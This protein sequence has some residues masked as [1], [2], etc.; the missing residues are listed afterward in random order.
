MTV[1]DELITQRRSIRKYKPEIPPVEWIEAMIRAAIQAPSPSNNQPVRFIRIISPLLKDK[2]FQAMADGRK[3]MLQAILDTNSP[4]KLKNWVS[5]YF[6]F[7]AF[8][9]HAPVLFALGTVPPDPVLTGK[10][11]GAGILRQDHPEQKD[12]DIAVGLSLMAYILKG[13][14]LGIGSCILT[15][16][17]FFIEDPNKALALEGIDIKC[18]ITS[19]YPDEEPPPMKRK[20]MADIC[21]TI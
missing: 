20:I 21:R 17:L 12:L 9:F 1:L 16:P 18:F 19:G 15:A 3:R 2:L 6:R 11:S 7:S 4:K 14:E 5:Y 10:L 8:M 13:E